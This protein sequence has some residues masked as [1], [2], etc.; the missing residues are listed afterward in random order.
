MT[1]DTQDEPALA[2]NATS[3]EERLDGL[4]AQMHA[5][6]AGHDDAVVAKAL[7]SR[8][9]DVGI[10]LDEDAFADVVAQIAGR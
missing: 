6:L 8:L 9:S 3:D 1:D 7:Q 4:I 5:D 10:A 2:Q